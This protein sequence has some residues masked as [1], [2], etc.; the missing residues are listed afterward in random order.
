[1]RFQHLISDAGRVSFDVFFQGF[2]GGESSERGGAQMQEVRHVGQPHLGQ[3]PWELLVQR[4]AGRELGDDPP[5]CLTCLTQPGQ[6]EELLDGLDDKV[7]VV[8]TGADLLVVIES[9]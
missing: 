7:T 2:L 6:P 8:E 9:C 5:G 4:A 3:R 1:M